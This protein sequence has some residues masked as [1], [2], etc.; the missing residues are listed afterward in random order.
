MAPSERRVSTSRLSILALSGRGF[1]FEP[2]FVLAASE[3]EFSTSRFPILAPCEQGLLRADREFGDPPK[4]RF[5]EPVAFASQNALNLRFRFLR[6]RPPPE[7]EFFCDL[8]LFLFSTSR[9]PPPPFCP[10]RLSQ[11]IS[12]HR[13]L[14]R[15][16][17][18]PPTVASDICVQFYEPPAVLRSL[19][20]FMDLST[21]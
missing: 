2:L 16:F 8:I 21:N 4:V 13:C 7:F 14:R 3:H 11:T 18:E 5:Y 9:S 15:I 1:F 12:A 20:G 17:Y 19:E 10:G 6:A